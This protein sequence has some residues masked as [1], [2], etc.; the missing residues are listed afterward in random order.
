MTDMRSSPLTLPSRAASG[1]RNVVRAGSALAL[2]AVVG[3][4]QSPAQKAERAELEAAQTDPD[5]CYSSRYD[6]L[7]VQA[8]QRAHAANSTNT[9][10][11]KPADPATLPTVAVTGAT[12][13]PDL[14]VP[15]Y[16]RRS[17]RMSIK[18]GDAPAETG[19]FAFTYLTRNNKTQ[20]ALAEWFPD[21]LVNEKYDD[22]MEQ[23]KAGLD[24]N[25]PD[26]KA[27]ITRY[28][29]FETDTTDPMVRRA[30]FDLRAHLVRRCMA[31]KA[32]LRNLYSDLYFIHR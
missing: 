19:F 3:C 30:A 28:P 20:S 26:L 9:N 22:T 27:C 32:A 5:F 16:S 23:I 11:E 15:P 17:C 8:W 10:D 1:W 6:G 18:V 29:G 21:S 12:P 4:A 13:M 25:N 24:M 2:L 14:S 7:L 31:N